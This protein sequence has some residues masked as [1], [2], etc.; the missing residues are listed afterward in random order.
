MSRT[1]Q[2]T[3]FSANRLNSTTFVICEDDKWSENPLIYAKLFPN[4]LVLIDTGCGGAAKD[5]TVELK[6]L[7]TFIE[8]YPV[9]DNEDEPLNKD[10][11]RNYVVI[12]THCHYDHI[13]G[14]EEFTDSESAIWASSF[15]KDF[16]QGVDRLPE[17]SL[18]RF[19][20]M[21]TPNYQVTEW[22]NNGQSLVNSQGEDLGLK[23]YHTPGHTP[24]QLAIWDHQERFLFV[25]DSIYEWAAILFPR[26]GNVT[27]YSKTIGKLKKLVQG[28]NQ[29]AGEE[30]CSLEDFHAD[31]GYKGINREEQSELYED[32]NG[33]ISFFGSAT[34][35]TALRNNAETV[36]EMRKR[37]EL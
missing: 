10:G 7:R 35:F 22:A 27:T 17:S 2:T 29:E 23:L 16:I 25:G 11:S 26:E 5:P 33:R 9:A 36:E 18:C 21:E 15:D 19:V 34:G 20:G 14:I 24:D 3:C 31:R 6:S 32:G 12:C 4:S 1:A 8:T 37:C 30:S 28:W 13:G